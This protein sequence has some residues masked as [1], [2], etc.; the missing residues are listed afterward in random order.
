MALYVV[1]TKGEDLFGYEDFNPHLSFSETKKRLF[2]TKN[3]FIVQ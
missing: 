3:L 1:F 2:M